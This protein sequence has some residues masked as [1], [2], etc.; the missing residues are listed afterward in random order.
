[1]IAIDRIRFL[2]KSG[3]L[4]LALFWITG[5]LVGF[6]F[7]AAFTSFR[8]S[9]MDGSHTV[10]IVGVLLPKLL[11]F[12][13]SAFAVYYSRSGLLFFVC[14][15]KSILFSFS[16]SIIISECFHSCFQNGIPAFL[17]DAFSS[18]IYYWYWRHA[19]SGKMEFDWTLTLA[20]GSFL[21]LLGAIDFSFMYI[22]I[23]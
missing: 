8:F 18:V 3:C 6:F 15:L 1:M 22:I 9:L 16:T 7:S 17:V 14:F 20:L 10:S 11:P 21:L 5:L 12:L 2:R 23:T 13:L 19:F 4:F